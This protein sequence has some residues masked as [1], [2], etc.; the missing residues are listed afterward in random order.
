ML[1]LNKGLSNLPLLFLKSEF[2]SLKWVLHIVKIVEHL[3]VKHALLRCA[4]FKCHLLCRILCLLSRV[5]LMSLHSSKIFFIT[6][7]LGWLRGQ[8]S[9]CIE[10]S[11][12][13]VLLKIFIINCTLRNSFWWQ[14]IFARWLVW[15]WIP[16]WSVFYSRK[17]RLILR[18]EFL[19]VVWSVRV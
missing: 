6:I 2:L 3:S 18:W 19:M 5:S 12:T 4:R 14:N 17:N 10:T 8:N 13:D 1:L 9:I 16:F 7:S 15:D 11:C